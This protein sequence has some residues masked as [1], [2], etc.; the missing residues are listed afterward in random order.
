VRACACGV[1]VCVCGGGQAG[2]VRLSIFPVV[3]KAYNCHQEMLFPCVPC[4]TAC[5]GAPGF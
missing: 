1:C 5:E 2:E 3:R 4:G